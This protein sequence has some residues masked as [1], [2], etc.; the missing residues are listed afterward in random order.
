MA[1]L[2]P[3]AQAL[4]QQVEEDTHSGASQ[5]ALTTLRQL[6]RYVAEQPA[7]IQGLEPLLA[8]ARK[9]QV[10]ASSLFDSM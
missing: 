9:S 8:T 6:H 3:Q 2:D 1:V 5:L 10:T 7:A 4:L